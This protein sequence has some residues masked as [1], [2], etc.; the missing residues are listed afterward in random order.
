MP[1]VFH[2][3]TSSN[4]DILIGRQEFAHDIPIL[5]SRDDPGTQLLAPLRLPVRDQ[6]NK[7]QSRKMDAFACK[8]SVC[9]GG[10]R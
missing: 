9:Q 6:S 4:G 1:H 3:M 10:F 5:T 2:M 8:P 7:E